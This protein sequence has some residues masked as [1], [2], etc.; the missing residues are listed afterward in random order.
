M[1]EWIQI[2]IGCY[3]IFDFLVEIED[4]YEDVFDPSG[5]EER[6]A[7]PKV[8]EKK[9]GTQVEFF[10]F[11]INTLINTKY[12]EDLAFTF[13]EC[14]NKLSPPKIWMLVHTIFAADSFMCI[15]HS[16]SINLKIEES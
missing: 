14:F 7:E 15:H 6:G 16:H 10:N 5:E 1:R 2:K 3:Q 11:D 4:D 9:E 12:L 13:Y 8:K